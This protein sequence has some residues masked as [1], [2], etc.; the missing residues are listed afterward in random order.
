MQHTFTFSVNCSIV[1]D[2]VTFTGTFGVA[3]TASLKYEVLGIDYAPPGAKSTVNYAGSSLRGTSISTAQ[4]F[5]NA[6]SIS[7]SGDAGFDLFGIVTGTG[8][9]TA[10]ASYTSESDSSSSLTVQTT[11]TDGDTI[12]GPQSSAAG[13][14]HDADIVW[15]WLNPQIP[16]TVVGTTGAANSILQGNYQNNPADPVGEMDIVAMP[17][18]WLKNPSLIPSDVLAVLARSWDTS[19]VGGLTTADYATILAQD[20]LA[21]NS[22]YDPNSDSNHR[23]DLQ[24]GSTLLYEPAAQG[25]SPSTA[26]LSVSAQST[27]SA[28]Q[29]AS[30][31]Y[32]VGASFTADA[33]AN[34]IVDISGNVKVT[35][36]ITNTSKWSSLI[37]SA[38][39]KTASLSITGPAFTDNYTG[40]IQ[41]QLWRDNIYGSFMFFPIN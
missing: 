38:T 8:T 17:V 1:T 29:G 7:T 33:Q 31:S 27:S 37:N 15:L 19:G 16:Y 25:L 39:T 24:G 35:D 20:P 21:A 11:T 10:S 30:T 23:Y 6:S 3:G 18:I 5:T 12:S 32:S 14:D 2:V 41:M 13:V 22:S 28:G 40:P 4:S 9:G 26:T 36:T 34:F